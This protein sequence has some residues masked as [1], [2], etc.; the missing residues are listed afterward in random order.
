MV[1][2]VAQSISQAH[3]LVSAWLPVAHVNFCSTTHAWVSGPLGAGLLGSLGHPRL[4]LK[5]LLLF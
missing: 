2:G 1:A 3:S 5:L 4:S